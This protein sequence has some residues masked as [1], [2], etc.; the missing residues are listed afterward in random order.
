MMQIS[1]QRHALDMNMFIPEYPYNC[2]THLR[3]G[4]FLL[5]QDLA[6]FLIFLSDKG[7]RT[8][9]SCGTE[10]ISS[11]MAYLSNSIDGGMDCLNNTK[12]GKNLHGIVMS[13]VM[14]FGMHPVTKSFESANKVQD[15][16][17]RYNGTNSLVKTCVI[18]ENLVFF[19]GCL[20]NSFFCR[21]SGEGAVMTCHLASCLSVSKLASEINTLISKN[22]GLEQ[23]MRRA[24][25]FGSM[26]AAVKLVANYVGC[27]VEESLEYLLQ[28]LPDMP[29]NTDDQ[30]TRVS[31]VEQC[32]IS[33]RSY[34]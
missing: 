23:D 14:Q 17:F 11:P 9:R 22:P 21:H 19:D 13:R 34:S 3:C 8:T 30:F 16:L 31:H 18:V 2:M 27:D 25:N 15:M 10:S 7:S 1:R 29:S 12:E 26:V 20:Y 24:K 4:C 5:T 32:L 28:G 6:E 33:N